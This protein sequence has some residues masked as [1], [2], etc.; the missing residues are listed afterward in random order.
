[1]AEWTLSINA[2]MEY[3]KVEDCLSRIRGL[4]FVCDNVDSVD[5]VFDD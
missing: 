5:F 3:E 2:T 4:G 1:M